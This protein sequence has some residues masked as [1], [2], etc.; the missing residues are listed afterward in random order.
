MRKVS[1]STEEIARLNREFEAAPPEA[2]LSWTLQSFHPQVALAAS[3]G[4][5]DVAL[6]DMLWR[7]NPQARVFTLDTQ[8]L[9]TETYQVI[10]RIRQ[11]YGLS[12]EI[13][14]PDTSKVLQM[15][16]EH[17]YNLF[18]ESV[19]QRQLCCQVRKVEPLER[20]LNGLQAWITGRRREQGATRTAVPKIEIDRAHGGRLKLNPLAG[21]SWRQVW[22]YIHQH[23]VPY[24]TLH[25]R[26][27]PSIGCAPCT[28]P[29]LPIE[30]PRAGRWWWEA[31]PSAKECGLHQ[32]YAAP[33][34]AQ[35]PT[36][37]LRQ[38]QLAASVVR[39]D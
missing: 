18:Y 10:D 36:P 4:A 23:D 35:T 38:P 25:D 32:A 2:L 21:W 15:V 24:N 17:G 19:E 30:D 22:E 20:A 16:R 12:L 5:E 11:R 8:R 13:Y 37:A 39:M 9:N 27:Y 1:W 34:P 26:D 6:I 31:D 29:V 3:F 7:L 28:R 14:A 33:P